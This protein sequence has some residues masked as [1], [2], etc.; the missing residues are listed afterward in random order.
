MRLN[1]GLHQA[2]MAV[3]QLEVI[4]WICTMRLVPE[5]LPAIT[6]RPYAEAG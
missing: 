3:R 4:P 2:L 5:Y 1:Q 6:P